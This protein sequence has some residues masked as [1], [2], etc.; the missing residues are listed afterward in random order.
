[1]NDNIDLH[2]YSPRSE[3]RYAQTLI[4][5]NTYAMLGEQK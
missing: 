4:R 5:K 2:E 3:T 1:M